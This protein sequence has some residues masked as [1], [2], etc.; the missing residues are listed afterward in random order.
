MFPLRDSTPSHSI[1]IV[2]WLI[3]AVN[4][5]VFLFEASLSTGE[6]DQFINTYGVVPN[7]L[8]HNFDINQLATIMSSMFLHGGWFHLI[9]N[10][11]ALYIF[12][13]NIEDRLG[14]FGYLIFYILC[15]ISADLSQ[16]YMAPNANVPTI[17][18][19]G[20]IAGVLGAYML[21]F[22]HARIVSLVPVFLVSY[23]T[24]VSAYFYLGFWFLSQWFTGLFSLG[25][26]A[27]DKGGIAWWA[28]VGGFVAGI[29]AVK[30][31]EKRQNTK[32]YYNGN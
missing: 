7:R 15:G 28:H 19:S 1:P 23:V 27:A 3:I 18:A 24:E 20:A 21:L 9:S 32:N 17:G 22:P 4:V 5:F 30:L 11:W 6:L 12:G 16:I 8:L 14:H 29:L 2:N 13:D 10:M 26:I 31:F 25:D